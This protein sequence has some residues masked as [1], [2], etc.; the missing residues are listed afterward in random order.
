MSGAR[1]GS[2]EGGCEDL[3]GEEEAVVDARAV[4]HVQSP[5][6]AQVDVLS[7]PHLQ[8]PDC[9]SLLQPSP[10]QEFSV[11]AVLVS[12][13][14]WRMW[15][16]SFSSSATSDRPTRPPLPSTSTLPF[17]PAPGKVDSVWLRGWAKQQSSSKAAAHERLSRP[18]GS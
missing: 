3:A 18:S 4:E 13:L 12:G 11:A 6:H 7:V 16:P 8:T 1:Q 9:K 10:P 17:V 15:Y 2:G 14:T 5:W